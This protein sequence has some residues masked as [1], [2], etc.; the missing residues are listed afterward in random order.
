MGVPGDRSEPVSYTTAPLHPRV[1]TPKQA[2]VTL[3][4]TQATALCGSVKSLITWCTSLALRLDA[5]KTCF[6]I[7]EA[8]FGALEAKPHLILWPSLGKLQF[9]HSQ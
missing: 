8:S 9:P 5:I 6:D 1:Q 7:S 3:A 4:S 2:A